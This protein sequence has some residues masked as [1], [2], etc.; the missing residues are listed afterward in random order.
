M[1]ESAKQ[2]V[3]AVV[4]S[5]NSRNDI[6]ACLDSLHKQSHSLSS[7]AVVDNASS[8]GTAEFIKE[9]YPEINL[10][11]QKRNEGFA[12]GNNIGIAAVRADWIL[13]LNPD[14][15]LDPDYIKELLEFAAN[16]PR[17]GSLTGKLL[18]TEQTYDG[19]SIIDSTG[20]EIFTSRRVRDRGMGCLDDGSWD[21]VERIFGACAAA[22]LYRKTML[23]DIST[24]GEIFAERFFAYYEDAD[25]AWRAWRRG[26]E[27]WYVPTAIAWHSR[28][29]SPVGSRFSRYLT[30]RNRLWLIARNESIFKSLTNPISFFIHELLMVFRMI[31]YP[32]LFKASLEAFLGLPAALKYRQLLRDT[33]ETEPP[34]VKGLGFNLENILESTFIKKCRKH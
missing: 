33:L 1:N 30:H 13:T 8:D 22:A 31:C 7:I 4:V 23:D 17:T 29:G 21:G 32:Y 19:E 11:V 18:K 3:A 12:K 10:L 24:D 26:W 15:Y 28:G 25:L 20:I 9:K 16:H 5:W 14:A 34:F 27:A 6:S 2:T